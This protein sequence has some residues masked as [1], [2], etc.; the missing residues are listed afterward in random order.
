MNVLDTPEEQLHES[1]NMTH[2][3]L[4]APSAADI[5]AKRLATIESLM[6]QSL[7]E[8]DPLTANLGATNSDL[9]E[10]AFYVKQSISA[11]MAQTLTS[12]EALPNLLPAM[13]M[14]L[15]LTRQSERIAKIPK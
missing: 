4:A 12:L 13:E 9:F 2:S 8:P 6:R 1:K 7:D 14:Y 5:T 11:S 3:E 15:K 10:M